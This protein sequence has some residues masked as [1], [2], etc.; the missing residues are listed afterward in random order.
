MGLKLNLLLRVS[1]VGR[2]AGMK[3]ETENTMKAFLQYECLTEG[4]LY[5][6]TYTHIYMYMCFNLQG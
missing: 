5:K 1:Y 4:S 2:K 3:K 6:N